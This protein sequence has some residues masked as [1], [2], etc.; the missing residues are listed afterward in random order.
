[1]EPMLRELVARGLEDGF[2]PRLGRLAWNSLAHGEEVSTHSQQRQARIWS[3]M[4]CASWNFRRRLD[5][6]QP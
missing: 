6:S 1:M 4:V 3:A 5:I 2:A